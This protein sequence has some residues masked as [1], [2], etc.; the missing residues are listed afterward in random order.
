VGIIGNALNI[1]AIVL[2]FRSPSL[3]TPFGFICASHLLADVGLLVVFSFWVAPAAL[4]NFSEPIIQSY[5]AERIG[6]LCTIFWSACMY[7]HLQT[8]LNRLIAIISPML[9]KYGFQK[10]FASLFCKN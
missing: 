1:L 5:L 3:H 7:S 8:A 10:Q 4:L 9:Y 6:Q 2:I